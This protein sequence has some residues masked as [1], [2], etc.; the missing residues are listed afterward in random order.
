MKPSW[1]DAPKWAQYLAMDGDCE[2]YWYA[3]KP[4]IASIDY[5]WYCDDCQYE[6]ADSDW[7]ESLESRPEPEASV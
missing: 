7:K 3:S 4:S 5:V 1:N 2:W 6:R